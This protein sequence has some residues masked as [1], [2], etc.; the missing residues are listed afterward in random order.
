LRTLRTRPATAAISTRLA[1]RSIA[2]DLLRIRPWHPAHHP[3]GAARRR[4]TS[5]AHETGEVQCLVEEAWRRLEVVRGRRR[6]VS[7]PQSPSWPTQVG[8][9][10]GPKMRLPHRPTNSP[11]TRSNTSERA[12]R[13]SVPT[14]RYGQ[15]SETPNDTASLS[16]ARGYATPLPH[17]AQAAV[18]RTRH[19][20]ERQSDVRAVDDSATEIAVATSGS[21]RA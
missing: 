15:S 3:S 4:L 9:V 6:R 11:L 2:P 13:S 7:F 5:G 18:H 1:H 16:T 10:P 14:A 21:N 20:T 17:L 12:A 8:H 19:A